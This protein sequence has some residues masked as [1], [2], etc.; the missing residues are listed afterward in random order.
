MNTFNKT[1]MSKISMNWASGLDYDF[2]F[3]EMYFEEKFVAK[4]WRDA[5]TKEIVVDFSLEEGVLPDRIMQKI[6]L[7]T[8]RFMLEIGEKVVMGKACFDI[9][10][11]YVEH[12]VN[13]ESITIQNF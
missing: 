6:S 13:T 8:F 9:Y 10:G 1:D 5:T 4:M 3:V 11:V 12:E 2:S 7:D